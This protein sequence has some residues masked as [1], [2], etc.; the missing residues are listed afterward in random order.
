MPDL[1]M[2]MW[3]AKDVVPEDSVKSFVSGAVRDTMTVGNG[4]DAYTAVYKRTI[5]A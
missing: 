5:A 4:I 2:A 3:V 1:V